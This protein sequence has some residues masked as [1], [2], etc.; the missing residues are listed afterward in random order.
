MAE[1]RSGERAVWS[2]GIGPGRDEGKEKKASVKVL[3]SRDMLTHLGSMGA[4]TSLK[5]LWQCSRYLRNTYKAR[6]ATFN[7]DTERKLILEYDAKVE[8]EPDG[9]GQACVRAWVPALTDYT[10][11]RHETYVHRFNL[12]TMHEHDKVP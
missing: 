6:L 2:R 4:L 9:E 7:Q 3:E 10:L 8:T 5:G 12:E 1:E 11:I